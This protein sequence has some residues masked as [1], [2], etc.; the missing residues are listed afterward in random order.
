[1]Y[2][3]PRGT[4]LYRLGGPGEGLQ[5][6]RTP[7]AGTITAIGLG[8]A[9]TGVAYAAAGSGL[10][11]SRDNGAAWQVVTAPSTD[12]IR[13]I[14]L[15]PRNA[16]TVYLAAGSLGV[17]K[18]T[19]AGTTW[20]QFPLE[21]S[22]ADKVHL[23]PLMPSTVYATGI[24]DGPCGFSSYRSDDGGQT[25]TYLQKAFVNAIVP[26]ASSLGVVYG[27]AYLPGP[28]GDR[29]YRLERSTDRGE[30]W[31]QLT[32]PEGCVGKEVISDPV[33]RPE[34]RVTPMVLRPSSPLPAT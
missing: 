14:A 12:S 9:S 17:L 4:N 24:G 5:Q 10:M 15:D 22:G 8:A 25:W 18:S 21:Y 34:P 19:D 28:P 2:P 16:S 29:E 32:M 30:T 23:D 6:L 1:M 7:L 20:S 31:T 13:G 3:T 27:G 33:R 26:D 11:R